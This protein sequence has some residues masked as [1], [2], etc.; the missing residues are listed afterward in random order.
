M[1]PF[2]G[3]LLVTSRF[4]FTL[5]LTAP[6]MALRAMPGAQKRRAAWGRPLG[7][8]VIGLVVGSFHK[9]PRIRRAIVRHH[10]IRPH[11]LVVLVIDDVA[12]PDVAVGAVRVEREVLVRRVTDGHVG[13]RS[14]PASTTAGGRGWLLDFEW[15]HHLE[16]GRAH[17]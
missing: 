13:R 8:G 1:I 17:V 11:H 16:I 14:A 6:S 3:H 9:I 5:R 15:P 10:R 7:C 2:Q 4:A 12:V